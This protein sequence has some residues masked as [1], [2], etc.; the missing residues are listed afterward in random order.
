MPAA[1]AWAWR[2]AYQQ[3]WLR[4]HRLPLPQWWHRDRHECRPR[5]WHL[6]RR[7]AWRDWPSAGPEHDAKTDIGAHHVLSQP[8]AEA[9]AAG[10][11]R[12]IEAA[13]ADGAQL[14][15]RLGLRIACVGA[16]GFQQIFIPAVGAPFPDIA[17]TVGQPQAVV[18]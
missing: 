4:R 14:V 9:G 5:W 18:A 13:A 7:V 17:A 16:D 6:H 15:A 12:R 3:P 8:V 1:R 11:G 10:H 2:R